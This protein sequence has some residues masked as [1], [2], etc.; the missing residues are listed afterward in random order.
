M[1]GGKLKN[2]LWVCVCV[3]GFA[4]GFVFV[5][6]SFSPLQTVNFSSGRPMTEDE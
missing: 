6:V 2:V 5:F 4:G 3:V 1:L